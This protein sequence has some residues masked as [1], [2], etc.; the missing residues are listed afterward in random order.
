MSSPSA[1]DVS[2]IVP[3]Y[4][5]ADLIG[6]TLSAIRSQS[7]KPAEIV[8]V[9][10][11]STDDTRDVVGRYPD[12]RYVRIENSGVCRARNLGVETSSGDLIAFCDSDDLW[13][14]THLEEQLRALGASGGSEYCFTNFRF[15]V[16]G[17]WAERTVLDRAPAD[18]W[19]ER[20]RSPHPDTLVVDV[21]LYDRLIRFQ[22]IFPSTLLMSRGFFERVGG[23]DERFAGITTE[24]FEF[25][26]RCNEHAG[27]VVCLPASVG[28]RKH[29]G[30]VSGDHLA[31]HLGQIEI[32]E[33]ALESH[34]CGAL[35]RDLVLERIHEH[36]QHAF[37]HA[38][39]RRES[40]LTRELGKQLEPRDAGWRR[41]LKLRTVL[42]LPTP[43]D[44]GA[45]KLLLAGARLV[46]ILKSRS[47]S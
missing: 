25:T 23:F 22:P 5:R 27:A 45:A 31:D 43:L 47:T 44:R 40:K 26:L 35:H 28:I 32:L 18:F 1:R 17:R 19:P 46:R 4:N 10:D 11:G 42:Q 34:A 20:R 16:D 30:N 15:V 37:D 41:R 13:L 33:H 38:F 36:R 24:D 39:D 14:A 7:V 3:T 21:P 12:V 9:D 29:G 8:V 2:V 6:Q